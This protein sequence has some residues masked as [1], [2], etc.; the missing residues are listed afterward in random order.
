MTLTCHYTWHGYV[1]RYFSYV[2][3][4]WEEEC[5]LLHLSLVLKSYFCFCHTHLGYWLESKVVCKIGNATIEPV[6]TT[7][8]FKYDFHG[9]HSMS[10]P[11]T[12]SFDESISCCNCWPTIRTMFCFQ[13]KKKL[14]LT[15]FEWMGHDVKGLCFYTQLNLFHCSG[16]TEPI[17]LIKNHWDSDLFSCQTPKP[18]TRSCREHF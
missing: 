7:V 13:R 9:C 4:P 15:A 8:P 12:P 17:L 3:H 18:L 1:V 6:H 2:A 14:P 11:Y 10:H 5:L 16:L